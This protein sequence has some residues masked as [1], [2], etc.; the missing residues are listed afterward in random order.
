M[1]D[2]DHPI[3]EQLLK[4]IREHRFLTTHQLVRLTIAEYGSLRS[5]KRQTLRHLW[6]LRDRHFVTRLERRIGGWQG[7]ST[8]TIW[9]LTT[10]GLR[11]LT[12]SR[13]RLRPHHYSTT[14][15]EHTLAVAETN[16]LLTELSVQHSELQVEVINEP[17][18]WR[19]YLNEHGVT[20]TLKPDLS[21]TVTSPE[22]VDRYFLEVDRATENP[23]RVIGK[24]W[25]YIQHRRSGTE[26]KRT[27]GIYPL[28]VWVVP[29]EK[30]KAQL[31]RA[32]DSEPKLQR[33]LFIVVTPN[34]LPPLIRDG[35]SAA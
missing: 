14:F 8:V 2:H 19:R 17:E 27:G 22:Y 13:S 24:C 1:F 10:K 35:P 5:A 32:M 3:Y 20:T 15:L 33:E 18:C 9:T 12:G 7:G 25:Q 29:N 26:Q 31:V 11:H 21:V 34:E 16:I 6:T 23:G 28:V 4:L 30:R